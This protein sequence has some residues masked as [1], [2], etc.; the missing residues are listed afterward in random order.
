MGNDYTC[1][2]CGAKFESQEELAKHAAEEHPS[3]EDHEGHNHD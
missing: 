1:S 2:G 3:K